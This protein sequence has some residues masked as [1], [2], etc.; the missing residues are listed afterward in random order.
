M[1]Q[2]SAYSFR[3][4]YFALPGDIT[5]ASQFWGCTNCNGN[6]DGIIQDFRADPQISPNRWESSIVMQHLSLAG[7]ISGSYSGNTSGVV[8]INDNAYAS[9]ISK[10][11]FTIS[12]PDIFGTTAGLRGLRA[13]C[14]TSIGRSYNCAGPG[15]SAQ[16]A[17]YAEDAYNIDTKMDD[18]SARNGKVLADTCNSD[19]TYPQFDDVTIFRSTNSALE[20]DLTNKTV[21]CGMMF[22]F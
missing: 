7:F 17:L 13:I 3:D 4:K 11:A 1:L 21:S 10:S 8:S 2:T 15:L 9:K 6:G 22:L 20:Y 18:G 12:R 19:P 14:I 5:N 16:Y